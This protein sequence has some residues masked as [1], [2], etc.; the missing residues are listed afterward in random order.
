MILVDSLLIGGIRFVLDKLAS[1]VDKE[2]NDDTHLRERLLDAQMRL[3]LGEIGEEEFAALES[4]VLARL[5][6][7]R[8][9]RQGGAVTVDPNEYKVVGASASFV[10]D[11]H[12]PEEQ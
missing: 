4:E 11:E 9:E 10:G 7:I 2:L 3:E 6:E 1:A 5:R 12:P 8:A